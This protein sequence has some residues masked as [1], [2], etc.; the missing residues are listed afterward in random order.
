MVKIKEL[1]EHFGKSFDELLKDNSI[2]YIADNSINAYNN[3]YT[4]EI[5]LYCN[6]KEQKDEMKQYLYNIKDSFVNWLDKE[7]NSDELLNY[8]I[9]YYKR[10]FKLENGKIYFLND[11]I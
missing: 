2:V 4:D 9:D 3:Y 8:E 11:Y 5:L 6:N 1:E 10:H 7:C